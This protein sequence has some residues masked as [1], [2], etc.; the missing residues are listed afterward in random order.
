[1][2]LIYCTHR[3]VR[4]LQLLLFLAT[5]NIFTCAYIFSV[6][7]LICLYANFSFYSISAHD[8]P[9]LLFTA[10]IFLCISVLCVYMINFNLWI[11]LFT[12]H[13][14]L[15]MPILWIYINGFNLRTS[16][17]YYTQCNCVWFALYLLYL[18]DLRV[19]IRILFPESAPL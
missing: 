3:M 14:W 7:A 12:A 19:V 9:F 5:V 13:I 2:S 15:N 11:I 4:D 10:H 8:L 1:M 16:N 18:Y 17:I 6:F